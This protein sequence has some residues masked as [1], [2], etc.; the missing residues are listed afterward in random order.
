MNINSA[1]SIIL[2]LTMRVLNG[3]ARYEIA[4]TEKK[5][6][7][8]G[9]LHYR[10]WKRTKKHKIWHHFKSQNDKTQLPLSKYCEYE[11]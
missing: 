7:F 3:Q 11:I 4:E 6:V 2:L 1:V 8:H 10:I 5:S 9:V